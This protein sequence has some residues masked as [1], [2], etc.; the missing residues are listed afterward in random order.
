MN[1]N[2]KIIVTSAPPIN[3]A[4]EFVQLCRELTELIDKGCTL[5]DLAQHALQFTEYFDLAVS[6]RGFTVHR[7]DTK[8]NFLLVTVIKPGGTIS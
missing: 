4:E 5:E 7:R 3:K 6:D 2:I 1:T 8:A